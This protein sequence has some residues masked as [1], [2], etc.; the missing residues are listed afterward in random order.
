MSSSATTH[1]GYQ[2]RPYTYGGDWWIEKGGITIQ[3][4]VESVVHARRII[5]A[6]LAYPTQPEHLRT[7]SEVRR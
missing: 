2:I 3:H 5:D 4:R 6:L 1:R 7:I